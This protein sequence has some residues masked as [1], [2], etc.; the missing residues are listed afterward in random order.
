MIVNLTQHSATPEQR[1]D[2]VVDVTGDALERLIA[3]LNFT[4]LPNSE[5][6]K[7]RAKAIADVASEA[8]GGSHDEAMIGGALWLM[9][10]LAEELRARGIQPL[11]AFSKRES[12]EVPQD[13]GS[14]KKVQIF[15]HIGFVDA[16]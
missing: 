10:P 9:A 11:F 7:K 16:V 12:D 3:A 4:V 14:V 15:R 5:E 1:A 2:G 13:D 8:L 6:I